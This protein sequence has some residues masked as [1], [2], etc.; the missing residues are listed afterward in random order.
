MNIFIS[1]ASSGI[2]AELAKLYSKD[3]NN[4]YIISHSKIDLLAKVSE[5]CNLNQANVFYQSADVRS[6]EEMTEIANDFFSKIGPVDLLIANAGIAQVEGI[7]ISEMSAAR[8][9]METNYFGV[10]NCIE[11]FLPQM[12]MH[13]KGQI[14]V[15]GS[16]SARFITRRSGSYSASKSAIN[17]WSKALRIKM[18]KYGISVSVLNPGFIATAMTSDNSHH[19]FGL[20]SAQSASKKIE[21]YISKKV[22]Q[23]AFPIK[24]RV[25]LFLVQIWPQ[26]YYTE[27]FLLLEKSF[28][29]KEFRK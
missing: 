14:V 28:G 7:D 19:M 2:G 26:K 13:K 12:K 22:E 5:Q 10:I 29:S 6:Y 4:I 23:R 27:I 21:K 3:N 16:I 18:K 24:A 11:A 8:N 15:I 1:G 20:I 25:L 9:N 17:V